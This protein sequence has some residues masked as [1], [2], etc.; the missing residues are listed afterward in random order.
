MSFIRTPLTDFFGCLGASQGN[1][2]CRDLELNMMNCLEAYGLRNGSQNC[3]NEIDDYKECRT[4]NKQR[5]RVEA[6]QKERL[7]QYK[8]GERSKSN[9]YAEPP[10]LDSF[11]DYIPEP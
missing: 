7:R 5:K 10:K 6:M 1:L 8:S 4:L 9:L 3:I 2:R 11:Y